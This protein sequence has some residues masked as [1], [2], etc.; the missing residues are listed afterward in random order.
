[1]EYWRP[2]ATE[3]RLDFQYYEHDVAQ[4]ERV[5]SESYA[6]AKALQQRTGFAPG[7][8]ATY[9]V[10][11]PARQ[12]KPFGLYS[13]GPGTSFSFD[14]FCANPADHAWQ[15]FSR[16]YNELAIRRLGAN[17]SPIQTQ[18]LKKKDVKI[19]RKLARPRFTTPY[20]EEFLA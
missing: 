8:W 4:L 5:V 17:A 3:R 9:F 19:P 12:Q 7:G 14:P 10:T 16:L 15:E 1:N 18:W 11:R 6:F 20:F 13:G 2:G